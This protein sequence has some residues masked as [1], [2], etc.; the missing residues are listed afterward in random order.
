MSIS[1]YVNWH[2][3]RSTYRIQEFF[4]CLFPPHPTEWTGFPLLRHLYYCSYAFRQT[5]P[6]HGRSKLP[7]VHSFSDVALWIMYLTFYG[8]ERRLVERTLLLQGR[9]SND[10]IKLLLFL[11]LSL[12][13]T[14][15]G[16]NKKK[17]GNKR[18]QQW[19]GFSREGSLQTVLLP[20]ARRT[21]NWIVNAL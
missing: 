4:V 19:L 6:P 20:A 1:L 2:K 9:G 15:G 16:G 21:S 17:M 7:P 8:N 13:A 10:F 12:Q 5:R 18:T 3:F 14:R 11:F